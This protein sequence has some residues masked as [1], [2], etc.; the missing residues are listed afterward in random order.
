M[1]R[2][3]A[4]KAVLL[5]LLGLMDRTGDGAEV[6]LPTENPESLSLHLLRAGN[7]EIFI[8]VQ[9][10]V[11]RAGVNNLLEGCRF[12]VAKGETYTS[13][14]AVLVAENTGLSPLEMADWTDDSKWKIV[15]L[16]RNEMFES[17][18]APVKGISRIEGFE[19]PPMVLLPGQM[20]AFV[21]G[22]E[23]SALYQTR[24][25]LRCHWPTCEMHV[26]YRDEN[27]TNKSNTL[28]IR[29]LET[30]GTDL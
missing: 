19:I 21:I 4:Y 17:S 10:F 7:A 3:V 14:I 16:Q 28:L 12:D 24:G 6:K 30:K 15:L 23:N 11:A 8:P 26:E 2:R 27:M 18:L 20:E 9:I 25:A 29:R 13:G 22:L 5:F 1:I